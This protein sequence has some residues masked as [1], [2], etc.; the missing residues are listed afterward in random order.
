MSSRMFTGCAPRDLSVVEVLVANAF[1]AASS[2][3]FGKRSASKP[4]T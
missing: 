4:L 2:R 3:F 1:P